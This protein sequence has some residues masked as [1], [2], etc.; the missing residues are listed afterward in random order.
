MNT[1]TPRTD[2]HVRAMQCHGCGENV[3]IDFAKAL[4]REL[5]K[6]QQGHASCAAIRDSWKAEALRAIAALH[7]VLDERPN[8]RRVAR[9]LFGSRHNRGIRITSGCNI[10]QGYAV[11]LDRDSLILQGFSKETCVNQ[12]TRGAVISSDVPFLIS[13]RFPDLG[14]GIPVFR[15]PLETFLGGI[16]GLL[17][18]PSSCASRRPPPPTP[19]FSALSLFLF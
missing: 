13:S 4:E 9:K 2:A 15:M 10:R 5:V 12:A 11:T 14:G 8:A 18:R 16:V 19:P 17:R 3:D 6:S 7:D 1:P